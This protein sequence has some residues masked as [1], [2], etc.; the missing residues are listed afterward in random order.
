[1][2]VIWVEVEVVYF[3]REDWTGQISLIRHDKSSF[4]RIPMEANED[5]LAAFNRNR[6]R[7]DFK[8]LELCCRSSLWH[9]S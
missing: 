1:M 8:G 5:G 6:K 7:L 4:R 2:P 3:S 9:L